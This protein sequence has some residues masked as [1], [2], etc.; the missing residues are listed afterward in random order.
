MSHHVAIG[1]PDGRTAMADYR[2]PI[3]NVMRRVNKRIMTDRA[4][5]AAASAADFEVVAR[6]LDTHPDEACSPAHCAP[7][8]PVSPESAGRRW[9]DMTP[10]D[11]TADPVPAVQLALFAGGDQLGTPDMF[12]TADDADGG[13]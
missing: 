7:H 10:A 2:H 6:W 12:V 8:G 1:L 3:V 11:F 4:T 5:A 13:A 9:Q